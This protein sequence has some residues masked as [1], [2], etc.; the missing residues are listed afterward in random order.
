MFLVVLITLAPQQDIQAY[1]DGKYVL[2]AFSK[3]VVTAVRRYA[4][5][6]EF[7]DEVWILSQTAKFV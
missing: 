4:Y 6:R 7:E 1:R 2:F 3:D 5:E